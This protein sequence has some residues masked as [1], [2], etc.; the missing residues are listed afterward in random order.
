MSTANVPTLRT[1]AGQTI[2]PA[3]GVTVDVR[4]QGCTHRLTCLV[5]NGN[6]PNLIG[7][8]WLEQMKL[9]C[10]SAEEV[11]STDG[12][13][14]GKKS[15]SFEERKEEYS[16]VPSPVL[17]KEEYSVVPSPVLH[18]EEYSVVPSPVLHEEEYAVIPSPENHLHEGRSHSVIS[19]RNEA[20]CV[21]IEAS[22]L[23]STDARV[24][25][26]TDSSAEQCISVTKI[27][28]VQRVT[29]SNQPDGSTGTGGKQSKA[30]SGSSLSS[31]NNLSSE[32]DST[33]PSQQLS[34]SSDH[35]WLGASFPP[36]INDQGCPMAIWV[37]TTLDT[38]PIDSVLINPRSGQPYSN[39]DGSVY[40]WMGLQQQRQSYASDYHWH[41]HYQTSGLDQRPY[42]VDTP[43]VSRQY[44]AVNVT[45][46]SSTESTPDVYSSSNDPAIAHQT[47]PSQPL[48]GTQPNQGPQSAAPVP[49]SW[50]RYPTG[51]TPKAVTPSGEQQSDS[52]YNNVPRYGYSTTPSEPALMQFPHLI[53]QAAEIYQPQHQPPG[54]Q[55]ENHQ[56]RIDGPQPSQGDAVSVCDYAATPTSN[57]AAQPQGAA[58]YG[59]SRAATVEVD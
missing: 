18:K 52:Q 30:D 41:G 35:V 3:G 34:T 7:R 42:T 16:V 51:E 10:D 59:R 38:I 46:E 28:V 57:A 54:V 27:S 37:A 31:P 23:T 5:V 13:L 8:D 9:E 19:D 14:D 29:I 11:D 2:K 26:S 44:I 48:R 53:V 1:Y 40:R 25:S 58:H 6:G 12:S 55:T 21:R 36:F 22:P 50:L 20:G 47:A 56:T 49:G 24:F 15:E 43:I 17:R 39:C 4:H 33:S 32:L 45:T